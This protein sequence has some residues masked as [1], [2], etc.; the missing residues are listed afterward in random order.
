M[1]V[2]NRH[3]TPV[4]PVPFLVAATTAFLASYVYLPAYFLSLGASLPV[5]LVG[6]T[7]VF[8]VTAI[9]AFYRCCWTARPELRGEVPA[10]MRM[11]RLVY[12]ILL[13]FCVIVLLA[14]PFL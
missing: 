10:E 8:V 6:A 12:G 14:L 7:L 5:A 4:D 3:G 13:G 1:K 2:V 11:H 9:G